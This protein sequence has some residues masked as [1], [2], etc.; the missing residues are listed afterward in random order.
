MTATASASA[1]YA[2]RKIGESHASDVVASAAV[3]NHAA[4]PNDAAKTINP[5]FASLDIISSKPPNSFYTEALY[6]FPG[7]SAARSSSIVASPGV[8]IS[9]SLTQVAAGR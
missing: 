2:K 1:A 9:P 8:R 7:D 3:T 6:S 4:R 5:M